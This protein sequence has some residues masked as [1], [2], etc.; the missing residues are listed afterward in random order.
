MRTALPLLALLCGCG[1][2][3]TAPSGPQDAARSLFDGKALG[4]WKATEFGGQGE[5]RVEN[6]RIVVEMGAALSGIH[7]T[8]GDVP[9]V[10][11]E[12]ALE[13]MKIDGSDFFCGI[14][15]PYKDSFCSFVAGGWGGGTTGL[16]SVDGMNASENETSGFL[17]F[18]KDR[19][20]A[21]RLRCT[22]DKIEVWIDG[23]Q[24][25]NLETKDRKISIHP[26]MELSCPLGLANFTTTSAFRN[27]TLR[28][29]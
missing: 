14:A 8:G 21:F 23:K 2:T 1:T 13:A 24:V 10:N 3:G 12:L 27:I 7:W 20:Y 19:W 11:Y 17:E 9:T 15:F 22:D 26:A 6:G 25:V 29:L 16:S 5:V 4:K 28:R 18:A